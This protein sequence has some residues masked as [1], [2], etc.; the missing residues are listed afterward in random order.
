[1]EFMYLIIIRAT[2]CFF[3][4]AE[5]LIHVK[6]E[7]CEQLKIIFFNVLICVFLDCRRLILIYLRSSCILICF[8]GKFS[9]LKFF[10]CGQILHEKVI[11]I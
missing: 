6:R 3:T 11:L 2:L 10:I 1:M 4:M 7:V 8:S 5:L 9:F